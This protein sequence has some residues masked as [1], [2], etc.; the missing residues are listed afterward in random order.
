MCP[1][2]I[3]VEQIGSPTGIGKVSIGRRQVMVH[4]QLMLERF[5]GDV[6]ARIDVADLKYPILEND[7]LAVPRA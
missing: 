6:D 4:G 5:P 3:V 1:K 2:R 7:L